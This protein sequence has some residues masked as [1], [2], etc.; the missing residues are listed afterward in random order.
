MVNSVSMVGLKYSQFA[1]GCLSLDPSCDAD[2][3]YQVYGNMCEIDSGEAGIGRLFVT[4]TMVKGRHMCTIRLTQPP[5]APIG[6]QGVVS[7][8]QL[9]GAFAMGQPIRLYDQSTNLEMTGLIQG[10]T[11]ESGF[12]VP[13]AP[14]HFN[15]QLYVQQCVDG[16]HVDRMREIYVRTV[17]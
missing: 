7:K 16:R 6:L 1:Q 2:K 15:V 11:L 3:I 17:D 14:H 13:E 8:M 9:F 4:W 5:V 10:V 12:T